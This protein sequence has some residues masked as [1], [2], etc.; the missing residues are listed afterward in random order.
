MMSERFWYVIHTYSGMEN[1]VKKNLEQRLERMGMAN[2]IFDVI[3][4]TKPE[5]ETKDNKKVKTD[6]KIYPG[7]VLVEMELDDDSWYVVRNT[8]GVTGFVGL[9]NKPTPLADKELQTILNQMGLT[10]TKPKLEISFKVNQKA[11]IID[12]PFADNFGIIKEINYE[13]RTAK[14]IIQVF[15]RETSVEVDFQ[16]IEEA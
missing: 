2:K 9:G 4:P 8:P 3:V 12:G 7:Y 5:V 15:N 14:V 11:R 10:D 13:K 6:R 1:K 16:Q